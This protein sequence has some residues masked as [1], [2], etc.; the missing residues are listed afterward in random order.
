MKICYGSVINIFQYDDESSKNEAPQ[1]ETIML[2][3][4]HVDQQQKIICQS[5]GE[6]IPWSSWELTIQS[7]AK[8]Q[9]DTGLAFLVNVPTL[10]KELSNKND[11]AKWSW[12]KISGS[13]DKYS[14]FDENIRKSVAELGWGKKIESGWILKQ[15]YGRIDEDVT[16][17][18]TR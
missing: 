11:V 7:A 16:W 1:L 4:Q 18:K 3:Y 9:F 6:K 8:S 15:S 5:E 14:R 10:Q 2:K 17:S 13:V 12:E